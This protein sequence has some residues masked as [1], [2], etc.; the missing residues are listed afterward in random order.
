MAR[1]ELIPAPAAPTAAADLVDAFAAWQAWLR[2]ERRASEHTIA[3]YARDIAAFVAF[4]VTHLGGPVRLAALGELRAADFRAFLAARVKRGQ[5]ATSNA[6][7]VSV[8][9]GFFRWL[10]RRGLVRNGQIGT[11]RSPKRPHAVPK[12]L[13]VADALDAVAQVGAL[14]EEPWVAARD[15]AILTLLY[16][17]GLRI[18]EALS[19][20][21][22]VL[23]LGETLKV[24]GKGRK[25]RIVPLLPVARAA[26][27]TYLARCPWRPGPGGPLFLGVRGKRLKAAIVQAR[28]RELRT[29]LGLPETATPHA[30]RHSFATHLLSA[31]GDL[32]AIQDLLGHASLSTTQRYTEVDAARMLDVY[33]R[34]HPRA[35]N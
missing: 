31:G 5:A 25:Q 7:A 17:A 27:D 19:L 15:A 16:G 9:R 28:M 6:R 2:L 4:L 29:K 35:K 10:D 26:I 8:L 3:A 18:D 23:P 13:T 24:T 30:L 32:R 12:P 21:R 14:A 11:L 1:P 22:G 20:N 33:D 34:A